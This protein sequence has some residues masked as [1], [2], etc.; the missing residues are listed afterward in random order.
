[1]KKKLLSIVAVAAVAVAAAW[2]FNQSS[3]DVALANV[4]L[5]NVE[6]LASGESGGKGT[7]Y[8]NSSGTS[9]C[10]CPGSNSCSASACSGC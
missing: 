7:L 9:F 2:G 4:A 6:A 10:C 5:S 3:N 1:M 8:G